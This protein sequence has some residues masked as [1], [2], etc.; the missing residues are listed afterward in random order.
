MSYSS[1]NGPY[2]VVG[3]LGGGPGNLWFYNSTHTVAVTSSGSFFTNGSALGMK[4]GDRIHTVELTTA[5]AYTGHA[6]GVISSV[7]SSSAA[8][9]TYVATST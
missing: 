5:G 2:M 8:T 7:A 3:K 6:L 1:T 9:V 4:V